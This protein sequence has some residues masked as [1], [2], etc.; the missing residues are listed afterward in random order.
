MR[1]TDD[2]PRPFFAGVE[3][4]PALAAGAYLMLAVAL[5][6][7][8][9]WALCGVNLVLCAVFLVIAWLEDDAR[10]RLA[11]WE[12][13]QQ[14]QQQQQQPRLLTWSPQAPTETD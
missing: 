4:V 7:R 13:Q 5:A 2:R 3:W 14:Q 8:Q 6:F 1:M 10:E 12:W 9:L 11:Q